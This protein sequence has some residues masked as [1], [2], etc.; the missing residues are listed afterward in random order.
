VEK[1]LLLSSLIVT[2]YL[3]G[4]IWTVQIVHYPLFNL[5]DR[6]SFAAF[7]AAHSGRI[8][9]IV[10][11]PMVIELGL[12]IALLTQPSS[13]LPSW[14]AWLGAGLVGMI[15]FSTF[16]L[17]VPQHAV[18]SSGFDPRAHAMLVGTN[19]VRTVAWTARTVLLGWLVWGAMR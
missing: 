3:T 19:W 4:L 18:L 7:E 8:S 5:A 17:Q 13:I 16:F 2:A 6:S 15:W 9:S 10:L 1:L 12:S 11:L 14:A